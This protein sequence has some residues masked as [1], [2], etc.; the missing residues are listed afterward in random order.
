MNYLVSLRVD[1]DQL[2]KNDLELQSNLE[3]EVF[4]VI[5]RD[6][7]CTA[8]V[9]EYLY[10]WLDDEDCLLTNIPELPFSIGMAIIPTEEEVENLINTLEPIIAILNEPESDT[11]QLDSIVRLVQ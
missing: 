8:D 5:V 4:Y 2:K 11:P 6:I 1:E 10:E 9:F 3:L 7:Q